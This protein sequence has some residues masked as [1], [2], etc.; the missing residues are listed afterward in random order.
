MRFLVTASTSSTVS[1][2]MEP[3]AVLATMML[4]MAAR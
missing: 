3:M 4:Q 2:T 1:N